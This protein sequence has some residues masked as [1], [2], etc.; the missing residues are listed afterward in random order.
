[1]NTA[2]LGDQNFK[3]TLITYRAIIEGLPT[4]QVSR[5]T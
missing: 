5:T 4:R 1:M 2:A 3:E